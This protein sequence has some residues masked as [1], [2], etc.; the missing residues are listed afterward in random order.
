MTVGKAVNRQVS[1]RR[2]IPNSSNFILLRNIAPIFTAF[3]ITNKITDV[4]TVLR[5]CLRRWYF[6]D[7]DLEYTFNNYPFVLTDALCQ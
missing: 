7:I 5:L 3:V 6:T 4:H 1:V 2:H